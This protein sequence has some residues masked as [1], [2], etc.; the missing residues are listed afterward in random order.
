MPLTDRH[1]A[2]RPGQLALFAEPPLS[3]SERVRLRRA[4]AT[5]G[6]RARDNYLAREVREAAEQAVAR[7][8]Y[9]PRPHSPRPRT[10]VPPT[11]HP[12]GARLL[13]L[14]KPRKKIAEMSESELR[15]YARTI[16]HGMQRRV[17]AGSTDPRTP[18]PRAARRNTG[19]NTGAH[20]TESA[21]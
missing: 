4:I 21:L 5:G 12:P 7:D 11:R 17:E 1:D 3:A 10:P 13:V 2:W 14:G 9:V 20:D 16:A 8:R 15:R 6:V 19:A 18:G